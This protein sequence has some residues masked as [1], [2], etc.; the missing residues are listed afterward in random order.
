MNL[1]IR[2]LL[3]IFLIG[4]FTSCAPLKPYERVYVD[5]PEM[6]MATTSCKNFEHYVQS[7]REGATSVGGTK[8]NGGC[9]CN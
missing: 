9:G 4:V 5:D 1:S 2:G 8:G 3:I 6:Q 7:I